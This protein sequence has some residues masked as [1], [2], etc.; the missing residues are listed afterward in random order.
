MLRARSCCAVLA[1]IPW[2]GGDRDELRDQRPAALSAAWLPPVR[3]RKRRRNS[4]DPDH[5][6]CAPGRSASGVQSAQG[7]QRVVGHDARP[8]ELPDSGLRVAGETAAGGLVKRREKRGTHFAKHA[9][10]ALRVFGKL[11]R[12]GGG[13]QFRQGVGQVKRDAAVA[14]T[15]L[16]TADPYD[17]AGGHQRVEI[18]GAVVEDAR[19]E[20]FTFQVG[21][22]QTRALQ[23]LD[24][25][26]DGVEAAARDGDAL[27]A[28]EQADD[29]C[30]A[31]TSRR[32]RAKVL[33]R[34]C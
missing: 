4:G 15:E 27:P 1:L 6:Q 22:G 2:G 12:W 25:I 31:T 9:G 29:V 21:G 14:I 20:D 11:G 16:F 7:V 10:D 23:D 28:G 30:S 17:I 8:H 3:A 24:G 19:G 5:R 34:T 26:E 18:V 33:R 13:E 32:R